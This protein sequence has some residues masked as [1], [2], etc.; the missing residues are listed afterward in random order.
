[1]PPSQLNL[2]CN[3]FYHLQYFSLLRAC[4]TNSIP[5]R[6]MARA[7]QKR[8]DVQNQ[9]RQAEAPRSMKTG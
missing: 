4:Q 9:A 3:F 7:I 2:M 8:G 1:M 6:S 5:H